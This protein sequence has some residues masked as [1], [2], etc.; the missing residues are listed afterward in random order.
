MDEIMAIIGGSAAQVKPSGA[1]ARFKKGRAG[2]V[3]EE[4]QS[5]DAVDPISNINAAAASSSNTK[6]GGDLREHIKSKKKKADLLSAP[7]GE[8][9]SAPA[10]K[11]SNKRPKSPS[12]RFEDD[13]SD[14]FSED[15][16]EILKS[17]QVKFNDKLKA[18]KPK[19][20]ERQFTERQDP[21]FFASK[22]KSLSPQDL[23]VH[24]KKLKV[25]VVDKNLLRNFYNRKADEFSKLKPGENIEVELGSFHKSQKLLQKA[26]NPS[27]YSA[28]I[29]EEL[30]AAP[31]GASSSGASSSK[32]KSKL[33]SAAN[34]I[35]IPSSLSDEDGSSVKSEDV[36]IGESNSPSQDPD[37]LDGLDGQDIAN[38][39]KS[40]EGKKLAL[41]WIK[42]KNKSADPVASSKPGNKE[43]SRRPTFNLSDDFDKALEV[44]AKE[45]RSR[46]N[47]MPANRTHPRVSSP[48]DVKKLIKEASIPL[49]TL[50]WNSKTLKTY[51]TEFSRCAKF[52]A[53][54]DLDARPE[55]V[56]VWSMGHYAEVLAK[57]A[58]ISQSRA[59][60]L[61][62]FKCFV[63]AVKPFSS[64]LQQTYSASFATLSALVAPRSQAAGVRLSHLI[65]LVTC[66]EKFDKV[67]HS[68]KSAKAM[69]GRKKQVVLTE[70]KFSSALRFFLKI[71][72]GMLRIDDGACVTTAANSKGD[73]VKYHVPH[74]KT[75]PNAHGA[76]FT[77]RCC[78]SSTSY[79][80]WHPK[81]KL[82][83]VCCC[84][85]S[86]FKSVQ[87]IL[88][89]VDQCRALWTNFVK[90]AGP[91]CIP[92]EDPS[93]LGGH[94]LR[95][96][97]ICA[98][99][100]C[101]EKAE[102]VCQVARHKRAQSTLDYGKTVTT[103]PDDVVLEFWPIARGCTIKQLCEN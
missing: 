86:E 17:V 30:R 75:D 72:W 101:G 88:K 20:L 13:S 53:K 37:P 29:K 100:E 61:S 89:N 76:E 96:G 60:Y 98:A 2:A 27:S 90:E 15:T 70:I 5:A 39:M 3:E 1:L 78:C 94:C 45:L 50:R 49:K 77:L 26:M 79:G 87:S 43:G 84:D 35:R 48:Q 42:N 25:D 4:E 34:P 103:L 38:L 12:P 44:F 63:A 55:C 68:P 59:T 32:T 22:S 19:K 92:V 52:C 74:S 10:G 93:K 31:S 66:E 14:E 91:Q 24:A 57:C 40:G 16:D 62:H 69:K 99:L 33:G 73:R 64:R 7:V 54:L 67:V 51:Q 80:P 56:S 8:A 36:Q 82:C 23:N 58:S 21:D 11:R 71:W 85:D 102:T 47:A 83:P 18:I 6:A 28:Y 41:Q 46:P 9:V 97:S 81:M 65:R 95:V